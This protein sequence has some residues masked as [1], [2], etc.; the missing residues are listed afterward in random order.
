[1]AEAASFPPTLQR[2]QRRTVRVLVVA[3]LLGAC[4]LAAGGTAGA[5]LGSGVGAVVVTHVM[6]VHGRRLLVLAAAFRP[7]DTHLHKRL[8]QAVRDRSRTPYEAGAN[9][10]PEPTPAV[11]GPRDGRQHR[12]VERRIDAAPLGSPGALPHPDLLGEAEHARLVARLRSLQRARR[13]AKRTA[14]IPALTSQRR[15]PT[16]FPGPRRS[17]PVGRSLPSDDETTATLTPTASASGGL[18]RST[19]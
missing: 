14:A 1:V 4:G 16:R 8:L 3:Q 13:A 18:R 12:I 2:L 19:L 5:L 15:Q 10:T 7:D 6:S 11:E 17:T 9:H